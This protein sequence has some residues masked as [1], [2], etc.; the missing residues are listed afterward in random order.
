MIHEGENRRTRDN[1]RRQRI[2]RVIVGDDVN[3]L[4]DLERLRAGCLTG[5][6]PE[7]YTNQE[8]D[9]ASQHSMMDHGTSLKGAPRWQIFDDTA[10]WHAH[11]L[12]K[13]Q[14]SAD[15]AEFSG[16]VLATEPANSKTR[17]K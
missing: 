12:L 4:L 7:G 6:A 10:T 8:A 1:V 2:E 9:R 16:P 17:N 5:R 13:T 3:L 11:Q 15:M 14:N